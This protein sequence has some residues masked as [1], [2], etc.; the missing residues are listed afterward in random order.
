MRFSLASQ[1][2]AKFLTIFFVTCESM[3]L[4]LALNLLL[5]TSELLLNI[6]AENLL[7]K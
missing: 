6:S 5:K 1:I 7:L 3:M 4:C 2:H